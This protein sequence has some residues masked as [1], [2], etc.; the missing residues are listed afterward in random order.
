MSIVAM[1]NGV[2]WRPWDNYSAVD[3]AIRF[4]NYRKPHVRKIVTSTQDKIMISKTDLVR[5]Y[6][7]IRA[8]IEDI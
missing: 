4:G 7:Q 1:K 2:S 5:A 8:A 6:C 3:A